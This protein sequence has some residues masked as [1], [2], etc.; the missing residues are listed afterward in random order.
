M[1]TYIF[2][3]SIHTLYLFAFGL[4]TKIIKSILDNS[5]KK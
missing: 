3:C 2:P 4:N 1:N 5:K